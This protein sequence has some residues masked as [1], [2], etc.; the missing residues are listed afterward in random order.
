MAAALRRIFKL[1]KNIRA[2][3]QSDCVHLSKD[4]R[5]RFF[6]FVSFFFVGGTF[7]RV[8]RVV[9]RSWEGGLA[10]G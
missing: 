5:V 6:F 3:Y 4:V 1:I 9:I 7:Q 8:G 2:I 10:G